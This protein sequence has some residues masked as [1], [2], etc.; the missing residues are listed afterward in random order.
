[1]NVLV[2]SGHCQGR[3]RQERRI[4]RWRLNPEQITLFEILVI[5]EGP[6]DLQSTGPQNSGVLEILS[7]A[8]KRNCGIILNVTLA[9]LLLLQKDSLGNWNF[10]I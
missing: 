6:L 9:E 5:L 1:M 3:A 4:R 7:K 2:R 8:E 10:Q